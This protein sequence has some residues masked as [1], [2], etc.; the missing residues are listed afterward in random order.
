MKTRI[1]DYNDIDYAVSLLQSGELVAFPTET[2]YGLG[3]NAYCEEAIK[4]IFAVKN[5]PQ[6]KPLI[7]HIADI[8]DLEN[9]AIDIPPVA[10]LLFQKFA[11]GPLTLVLKKHTNISYTIT[12]GGESVAVRIPAHSMALE[13]IKRAEFP[14]CAPSANIS[15]RISPTKASHVYEDMASSIPLILDGGSC[16]VGVESTILDLTSKQPIILRSGKITSNM[17]SPFLGL[18]A[19]L[20]Q[21]QPST[22]QP[23]SANIVLAHTPLQALELLTSADLGKGIILGSKD[24][25]EKCGT[26]IVLGENSE[27]ISK[28]IY[29]YLRKAQKEYHY[30][31][32]E[33]FPETEENTAL[34]NLISKVIG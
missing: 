5:R 24:F 14:I 25:I 4:K 22:I 15:A 1:G 2:V 10:Y 20:N 3:A 28:N 8:Q 11:P 9:V 32:I 16:D 12:A 26:G 13:L 21:L 7:V 29:T 6:D 18:K 33:K 19:T 17:L 31:I 27:E 23:L 34:L 30:I